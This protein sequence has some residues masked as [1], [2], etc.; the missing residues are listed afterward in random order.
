[1]SRGENIPRQK[2][3]LIMKTMLKVN[4]FIR[5]AEFNDEYNYTGYFENE[6]ALG[7]FILEN[8]AVE[9][10]LEVLDSEVV[11][12]DFQTINSIV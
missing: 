1:V 9:N 2:E 3:V 6:A 12:Y 10:I 7:K 8:L 11:P 4:F 5:D